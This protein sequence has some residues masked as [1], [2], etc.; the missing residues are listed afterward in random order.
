MAHFAK[1]G[2]NNIVEQVVV[3]N[4]D[5]ITQD[6]VENEQLGVDFLNNLY[7][8]KDIWIQTSYNASFRYN[9]AVIG[10]TYNLDNDAFIHPK[11]YNSWTLNTSNYQWE[12]PVAKPDDGNTYRWN[13]STQQWDQG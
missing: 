4:N 3:V 2:F 10:G 7:G 1:I 9:F 13:E 11:P 8:T 5:V 12:P 6:G